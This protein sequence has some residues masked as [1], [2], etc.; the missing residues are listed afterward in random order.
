MQTTEKIW[1]NGTFV[2][3]EQAQVHI[4]THA[5]HY[6]TGVFEGIRAYE[7][8]RGTAVFRLSDHLERLRR[9]AALYEMDLGY[10][11][12]ELT[13]A[14]HDT[15]AQNS[16]GSCYI[17]PIV[18]RGYGPMG[19]YP[20]DNPVDVAIA[21]WPWGA[22]LGEEALEHGVRCKVSSFRRIGPNTLPPAA[23]ATGQYINSVLAK[24][25]A[26]RCGYDEAILLNSAGMVAE[27]PGEN[28]FRVK[29]GVVSTPP[30]SSG[31]LRGVT[32]DTVMRFVRDEG[33]AFQR[34]DFTREELFTADEVFF[35]GTAV[36]LTPVREIDGRPIGTGD[37]PIT[38]LLQRRYDDAIRGRRAEYRDW[39]T[40]V[41]LAP[42]VHG[43]RNPHAARAF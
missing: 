31:I 2:P 24:L 12:A 25:E 1:R 17:R 38:R 26:S 15:I 21:V 18:F 29:A 11:T 36:G 3:W 33:L 35:S 22:Y 40:P 5:L 4:L 10:S 39:L 9:S 27:G 41:P 6:G 8:D 34:T 19:L 32:R 20:G 43:P 13:A 23:K 14:V 28:I 7:T 42:T 16:I 30:A 37:Y